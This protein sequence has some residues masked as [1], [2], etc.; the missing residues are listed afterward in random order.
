MSIEINFKLIE[1][2]INKEL[3]NIKKLKEKKKNILYNKINKNNNI[4]INKIIFLYNY[5][6]ELQ[7]D[8]NK[9]K[10]IKQISKNNNIKL[11]FIIS[12][13]VKEY[14]KH[15]GYKYIILIGGGAFGAVYSGYQNKKKYS[16][17]LQIYNKNHWCKNKN[18]NETT[19]IKETINEYKIG[20]K[21]GNHSIGPKVHKTLFIYD[22]INDKFI[23]VII[24]EYIK[25]KTLS[26]YQYNHKLNKQEK[27][28]LNNK[29][30][31]LHKLNIYHRD[32]HKSNIMVIKKYNKIDFMIIDFGFSNEKKNIIKQLKERNKKII[33]KYMNNNK[34]INN[35][36]IDL[37]ITI[38]N[39]IIMKK[40]IFK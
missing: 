2:L 13:D 18:Y 20:K 33:N 6:Y 9:T 11:F 15:I 16:I 30:D 14:I 3:I 34:Y 10:L 19:F 4:N 32:L 24:M 27:N 5:F 22:K 31:K 23:N 25:G 36:N 7:K 38:N 40:I 29:I 37:F 21:L 35:I 1:Q 8:N 17:K 26:E 28:K 39:L 12:N